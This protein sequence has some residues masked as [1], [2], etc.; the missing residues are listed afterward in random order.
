MEFHKKV[1]IVAGVA[2]GIRKTITDEFSKRGAAV[3]II[4]KPANC[5]FTSDIAE[6][7]M[8]CQF[9]KKIIATKGGISAL[10][11]ALAINLSKK[12]RVNSISP[13]WIKTKDLIYERIDALQHPD[14]RVSTP[15]DIVNLVL[16]L[17]SDKAGFITGENLCIDEGMTRQI[18]Y[19]ND[20]GWSLA[21][22]EDV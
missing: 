10:T 14:G 21:E 11:H 19:H 13:G 5:Y 20:F 22:H 6:K 15:L 4:D 9:A 16:Y 1:V 17:C 3:C 12:I 18:V 7:Q 2:K 8:L